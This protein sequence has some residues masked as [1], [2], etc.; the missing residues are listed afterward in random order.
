MDNKTSI[1]LVE[2]DNE[3]SQLVADYLNNHGFHVAIESQGNR[4]ATHVK[5]LQPDLII[6]DI[7]LPERD[8]FSVCKELRDFYQ[9]PILI[10]TANN[11]DI[12]Q[13][14][15]LE[16]GADD[17][18]V[19]P[20]EPRVLL[21]RVRA[22][23]RR[24]QVITEPLADI[25]L[26]QL[27]INRSAREACLNQQPIKLSSHEFDLLTALSLRA[28]EVLS[29]E[30]LYQQLYGREYDGLDRALDVKISHLRKK[31]GDDPNHPERIKTIWGQG[32][33]LVADAWQ[34]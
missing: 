24:S 16:L 27:T 33:L 5:R 25:Q 29:R 34:V 22:L 19:K 6:L 7:G 32:Y 26:G 14:L 30:K 13:V 10:L 31:L 28:G 18:V 9:Q 2:D 17:Y 3:L 12:D 1:L 8:G 11:S 20:A 4:V 15:G 23:L 21:A